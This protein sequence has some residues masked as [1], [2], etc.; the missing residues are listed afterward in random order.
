MQ[1]TTQD[2]IRE[3]K[4]LFGHNKP[5][6]IV[7]H[8]NQWLLKRHIP[9]R[10]KDGLYITPHVQ[11]LHRDEIIEL[12]AKNVNRMIVLT[13]NRIN[14]RWMRVL[15][16]ST[17]ATCVLS[18]PPFDIAGL[19]RLKREWVALSYGID[20]DQF[21]EVMQQFGMVLRKQVGGPNDP[22]SS[23]TGR[24]VGPNPVRREQAR[25]R[26]ESR[27]GMVIHDD[28][29]KSDQDDLTHEP[30]ADELR[31]KMIKDRTKIKKPETEQEMTEV[32]EHFA[33]KITELRMK[34]KRE[35]SE[36]R[37]FQISKQI[38]SQQS[39]R[40]QHRRYYLEHGRDVES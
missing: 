20:V 22:V 12:I 8:F 10:I 13:P 18:E 1:Y 17:S 6:A 19:R 5:V 3:T 39:L 30:T 32:E 2:I 38:R 14:S 15:Y 24:A 29:V 27:P 33:N 28:Q 21:E 4:V 11:P 31:Q 35:T 16:N 34:Q 23:I 36:L 37:K 40:S 25:A 26:G 9:R 7:E